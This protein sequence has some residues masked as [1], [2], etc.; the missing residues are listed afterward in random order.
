MS[1]H[2]RQAPDLRHDEG[3]TLWAGVVSRV[4]ILAARKAADPSAPRRYTG[5][6]LLRLCGVEGSDEHAEQLSRVFTASLK[7]LDESERCRV[8]RITARAVEARVKR[9]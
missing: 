9:A 4:V 5:R 8:L 1:A 6:D 3:G 2:D 7:A